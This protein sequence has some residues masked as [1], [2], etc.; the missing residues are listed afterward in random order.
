MCQN[1]LHKQEQ[2]QSPYLSF[3]SRITRLSLKAIAF[4]FYL[5]NLPLPALLSLLTWQIIKN[6]ANGKNRICRNPNS[7]EIV[8][9]S[10]KGTFAACSLQ[11]SGVTATA[12]EGN[13][14]CL[15]NNHCQIQRTN[16]LLALFTSN[17]AFVCSISSAFRSNAS[18]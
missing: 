5:S 12:E 1:V 7:C 17:S 9:V 14:L 6:N 10:P 2:S 16:S 15:Y 11:D 13:D 3:N 8:K 4:M 18:T